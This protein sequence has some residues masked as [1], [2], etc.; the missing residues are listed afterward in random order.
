MSVILGMD[1]GGTNTR[2]AIEVDGKIV[3][4]ATITCQLVPRVRKPKADAPLE[5]AE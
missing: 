5:T 1:G 3:A 4:D 2:A